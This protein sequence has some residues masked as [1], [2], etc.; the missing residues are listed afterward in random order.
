MASLRNAGMFAVGAG[1]LTGLLRCRKLFST[2]AAAA[3][4]A[5]SPS[6]QKK[7]KLAMC[8]I[9]VGEDKKDNLDVAREAVQRAAQD[10]AELVVLPECFNSPYATDQFPVYAEPIP[11]LGTTWYEAQQQRKHSPS[12]AMLCDVARSCGVHLVGGSI[13][14]RVQTPGSDSEQVYNSCVVV[15]PSGTV[16]MKHRK[17][18]LFDIDVPGKITFKESDTLSPGNDVSTFDFTNPD[19]GVSCKVGVGICYDMRF[20]ELAM[21]MRKQGCSLLLYPGAFNMTTGP[22]HWELLQR[23]R[24]LDNQCFVAAVSPARNPDSSYQA[25]GHSTLVSPWGDIICTTGHDRSTIIGDIDLEQVDEIRR[26]IPVSLQK[27]DD[28][29]NLKKITKI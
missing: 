2:A 29:Y 3:A 21:L 11:A 8:Q 14:E 7:I 5:S 24:A 25:W 26:N 9:L 28:I 10:G 15:D 23:A 4:A 20:P 1:A 19:T 16:V 12:T 13:P 22:A 27:R 6:A 17:M 18:H